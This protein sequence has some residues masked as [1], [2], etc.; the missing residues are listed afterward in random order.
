VL[1]DTILG[2]QPHDSSAD[3][4]SLPGLVEVN[5]FS[6]KHFWLI[7][8]FLAIAPGT[9]VLHGATLPRQI[10]VRLCA[11]VEGSKSSRLGEVPK[12]QEDIDI[13]GSNL[14]DGG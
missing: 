5:S 9:L 10:R 7:V 11:I 2:E 6:H 13:L 3:T 14:L 12:S 1:R 4:E 8:N